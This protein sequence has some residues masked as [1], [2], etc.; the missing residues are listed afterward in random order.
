MSRIG[1][2]VDGAGPLVVLDV[3]D[4]G[5]APYAL[6][7]VGAEFVEVD[8]LTYQLALAGILDADVG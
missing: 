2:S 6:E 3:G 5:V 4:I 8:I 7:G 1:R